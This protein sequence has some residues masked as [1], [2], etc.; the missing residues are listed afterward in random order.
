MPR[1]H[2]LILPSLMLLL[3]LLLRPAPLHA[4][5]PADKQ[6]LVDSLEQLAHSTQSDTTRL[7]A[8]AL[9][10]KTIATIDTKWNAAL[11][12]EIIE[13]SEVFLQR[14]AINTKDSIFYREKLAES[15]IQLGI[16]Y[17]LEGN[18]VK[19]QAYE[20]QALTS[21]EQL[22][23]PNRAALACIVLG[24]IYQKQ[25]DLQ[26]ALDYH[27]KAL[28]L[29][30]QVE[31]EK[32]IA[33]AYN[34]LGTVHFDMD[35]MAVA[36][37]EF[38]KSLEIYQRLNDQRG[39]GVEFLNLG[40]IAHEQKEFR[41]ANHFLNRSL[42]IRTAI[43][44]KQGLIATHVRLGNMMYDVRRYSEALKHGKKALEYAEAKGYPIGIRDASE[45]IAKTYTMTK[46]YQ[47][48]LAY[49]K[50]FVAAKDS[51][52]N[53]DNIRAVTQAEYTYKYEQEL[54]SDSIRYAEEQ[55]AVE[56][57]LALQEAESAQQKLMTKL[58]LGGILLL[59]LLGLF[60]YNRYQQANRQKRIIESQ[61]TQV[62]EAMHALAKGNE[63]KEVLLKEIHHRVKN[64]LQIISSLL[65]L[66][67]KNMDDDQAL[68][69]IADGQ[70]R[71][72]AMAL[73]H[74]KLYQNEDIA[75]LNFTEYCE[76]LSAQI[77]AIHEPTGTISRE[78]TGAELELDIDTAIPIGL[79]LSEL[80]TN[81]FKYGVHGKE[82][83]QVRMHLEQTAA[84]EY[85]IRVSD[86][87]PGMPDDFDLKK[88]KSLGLRLVRRL[89]RQLYGTANY[90]NENGAVFTITFKDTIKRKD[91][92]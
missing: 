71:V 87:G 6:P 74:E 34:N 32:G 48:A 33:L 85:L 31:N 66:Q 59:I 90:H 57:K 80:L 62:E 78:V 84:G 46:Q 70:N 75:K 52:A 42:E 43:N 68:L 19:A 28:E 4:Q 73:I 24:A 7:N 82:D 92:L 81:A 8:L 35:S 60:V 23:K 10:A 72:K 89:S 16:N 58:L 5:I 30:L 45:L 20:L 63:E 49:H 36:K 77:A 65:D 15:Q 53:E 3:S 67:T 50:Q 17:Y 41:S 1:L 47:Q 76:Q 26:G 37:V 29:N 21:F 14:E 39:M 9:L 38:E 40:R 83:G 27:Q 13:A 54:A 2:S 25:G 22:G 12:L 86:N 61:K 91:V 69:A 18:Y 79:I 11:H 64:N 44:D 56:V 55:K 51:V 88:A